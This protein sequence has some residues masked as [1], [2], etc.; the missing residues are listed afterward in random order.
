M[1]AWKKICGDW[2]SRFDFGLCGRKLHI[3]LCDYIILPFLKIHTT[4]NT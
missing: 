3:L 1:A 2:H 4:G